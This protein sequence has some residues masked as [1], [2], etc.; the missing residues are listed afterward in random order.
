MAPYTSVDRAMK[1]SDKEKGKEKGWVNIPVLTMCSVASSLRFTLYTSV[2]ATELIQIVTF[3][4]PI[5]PVNVPS[6]TAITT[7][8]DL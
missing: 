8:N 4:T 2:I 6:E 5:P 7:S 3:V 1:I